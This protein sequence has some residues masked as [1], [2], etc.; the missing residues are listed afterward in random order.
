MVPGV[1]QPPWPNELENFASMNCIITLAAL[2]HK[3]ISDPDNTY[4]KTG[5]D[6]IICQSGGGAGSKKK[7]TQVETALGNNVEFYIDNLDIGA[8]ITPSLS[9]GTNSNVTKISFEVREP[10]SMGLFLSSI[11]RCRGRCRLPRLHY[12]MFL[13][14]IRF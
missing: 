13:L 5:L 10:Y 12:C 9:Y 11:K 7:K 1:S 4:R 8:N 6:N 2:S 14:T 3:Q